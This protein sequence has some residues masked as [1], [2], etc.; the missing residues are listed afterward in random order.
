MK[1]KTRTALALSVAAVLVVIV[2]VAA[3]VAVAVRNA[4]RPDPTITAYAHGK[5]VTVP[6]YRFCTVTQSEVSGQ[7]GLDCRESQVT[8]ELA[9]PPGY[10]VQLSLPRH[11]ADA[12]WVMKMEY[13]RPDGSSAQQVATYSDYPE[14][15]LAL[16]VDS[17]P[18]PDLRLVGLVVQLLV[19][20]RDEAG[21]EDLAPYQ[22]W[23][24]KTA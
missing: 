21:N 10:P 12:P 17:R 5:S 3:V 16:T 13:I 14:G 23:S 6:P 18:E 20:V 22:E 8:V 11:I 7:L 19:P 4:H 9:T 2:A 15:T 24:I 1:P